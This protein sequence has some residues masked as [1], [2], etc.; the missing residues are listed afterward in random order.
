MIN[1]T[2]DTIAQ[3]TGYDYRNGSWGIPT[4]LAVTVGSALAS[5][6]VGKFAKDPFGKIP[7]IGKYLRL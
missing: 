1:M 5:Q 7:I 2:A 6:L 3:Y 4:G